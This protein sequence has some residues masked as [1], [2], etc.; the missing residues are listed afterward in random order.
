VLSNNFGRHSSLETQHFA[1]FPRKNREIVFKAVWDVLE[2]IKWRKRKHTQF[3]PNFNP[4]TWEEN[5]L[6]WHCGESI[7][8]LKESK[9]LWSYLKQLVGCSWNFSF[10]YVV[11]WLAMMKDVIKVLSSWEMDF[12]KWNVGRNLRRTLC[13]CLHNNN[14]NDHVSLSW[15]QVIV[16]CSGWKIFAFHSYLVTNAIIFEEPVSL[17]FTHSD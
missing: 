6:T 16:I 13:M 7:P 10:V 5:C 14:N 17:R 11:T 3:D 1:V 9:S 4:Y 12:C 8:L 2:R 15:V